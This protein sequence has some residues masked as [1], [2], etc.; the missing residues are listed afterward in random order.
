MGRRGMI[1]YGKLLLQANT[2]TAVVFLRVFFYCVPFLLDL[3]KRDLCTLCMMLFWY[4][5]VGTN[6]ITRCIC[7][8]R[9]LRDFLLALVDWDAVPMTM[10]FP[11]T[12]VGLQ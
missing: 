5:D 1:F 6:C 7:L 9:I 2:G 3:E 12:E 11:V 10:L 4:V 8:I